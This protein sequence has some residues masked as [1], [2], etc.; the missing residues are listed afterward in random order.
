MRYKEMIKAEAYRVM[1]SKTP[2]LLIVAGF[3]LALL[4]SVSFEPWRAYGTSDWLGDGIM[5][6]FPNPQYGFKGIP[7]DL[8]KD[9]ARYLSTVAP[10]AHSLF[11]PI[12]AVLVIGY[13]FRTPI[14]G[15]QWLVSYAKGMQTIQLLVA[16]TLVSIVALV[17]G[18]VLFS[19]LVSVVQ[20]ACGI[21]MTMDVIGEFLLRLSLAA[22]I[23]TTLCLLLVLAISLFGNGAFVLSFIILLLYLGYGN[24][25]MPL[26]LTW[27]ATLASPRSI[28]FIVPGTLLFVVL[29]TVAPI[30][31]LGL[32]WA[33]KGAI[34][35]RS[36]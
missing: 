19:I 14:T 22:L 9:G 7:G 4:Y 10:L 32:C 15:S 27:L 28:Q 1:K 29:A 8:V 17:G 16:R 12:V 5:G 23:C 20:S 2:L 11:F 21:G 30:V 6:F 34:R 26:H 3:V 33:I 31:I 18:F 13:A 36:I 24:A 35:K 25:N